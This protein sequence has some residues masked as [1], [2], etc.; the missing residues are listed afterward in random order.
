MSPLPTLVLASNNAKKI[1]ELRD[2][3]PGF[4]LRSLSDMGFAQ[5]IEEPYGTF[6][7]NAAHKAETVH[8]FCGLPV[9]SDDSGL[10][11]D[12]LAGAPGVLS[13]RYA[14]EHGNDGANNAKLLL[15]LEGTENRNAR[16]VCVIALAGTASETLLFRGEWKG[17]IAHSPAGEQGFGY[18]PLFIPDGYT[19]SAAS[20]PAAVKK[21][22]SHRAKALL[23]L[24]SYLA[25]ANP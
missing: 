25:A 22:A 3:L 5:E 17:R 14:G 13:A 8:R 15:A 1:K 23:L 18:D 16:F 19:E 7:Q 2:L 4:E 10:C 11:V 12:A 9:L 24:H 20:L 21:A 6:E